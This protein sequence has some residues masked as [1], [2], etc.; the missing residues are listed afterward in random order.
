MLGFSKIEETKLKG[1]F[2]VFI[3]KFEDSRGCIVNLFNNKDY[4]FN[5]EK[6]TISHKNVLRGLHS[7]TINDKLIYCLRGKF[8]LVVVNYDKKS[9]Q[10]LQKVEFE[11]GE[12]SNYAVFVP[13]NFLNGHYCMMNNTYF[14][15]KWSNGYVE[16]EKQISIKWNSPSLKIKWP[17]IY[18]VP[19]V[20]DRDNNSLSI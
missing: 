4:H 6:L 15:Y 1:V 20:S 8:F 17:L 14:Y 3:E 12:D 7:D 16:P 10:Y 11:I 18:N 9:E 2:K 13:K 5:Q 19:I